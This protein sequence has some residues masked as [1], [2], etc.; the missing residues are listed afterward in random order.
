MLGIQH[1]ALVFDS[2]ETAGNGADDPLTGALSLF[3]PV[4]SQAL[5]MRIQDFIIIPV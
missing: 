5:G 3:Y 4:I 2:N 1:G